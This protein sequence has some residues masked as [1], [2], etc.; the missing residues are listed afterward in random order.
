MADIGTNLDT[1][2]ETEEKAAGARA[3]RT[4]L[5]IA[6]VILAVAIGGVALVFS[7]VGQDRDRALLEWQA[8]MAIVAD[9]RTAD[10]E[11]W[12]DEQY[13]TLSGLAENASLQLYVTTL[14]EGSAGAD[15]VEAAYLRNL[16]E[17]TAQRTGFLP[18]Q[19]ETTIDANVT[20]SGLGGLAVLDAQGNAVLAVG[21]LPPQNPDILRAIAEAS[22][23]ARAMVPLTLGPDG[24]PV[25]GFAVPIYA[26]QG[27]AGSENIGTLVGLR[28]VGDD[29]WQRLRQPG[30]TSTTAEAYLVRKTG[31]TIE[32]LS[33]LADGTGPLKKSLD[34]AT[35]K[36]AAALVARRPGGFAIGRDYSGRDVL[37]TGR[38]I[39][40]APW[41]LVRTVAA[42]EALAPIARR[43][44]TLITV[45][46]LVI[47]GVLIGALALWRHGSSLRAAQSA[48][49]YRVATER[50]GNLSRF[51]R[52]VTDGQPTAISAVD[53]SGHYTFLNK[54]AAKDSGT[55]PDALI[56]KTMADVIGP[57]KAKILGAINDKVIKTGEQTSTIQT[58]QDNGA[59]RIV[60]SD[61][62]PLAPDRDHPPGVLMILEDVTELMSERARAERTMRDLVTTL[63]SLV[64]RRDPYSADQSTR[65]AQVSQAIAR[66]MGQPDDVVQTVD[67]AGNL[68]NLGKILVP[69]EILTK[70]G[71][72]SDDEISIVRDSMIHTADLLN[73]VDF[74]LP[75]AATLRQLQEHWDG[76]GFPE[77]LA[78]EDILLSARIVAVANAFV[79]MVSPRAY[80]DAMGFDKAT[81]ILMEDVG[82]RYDRK[83]VA[84]LINYL[85]NR[86]GD[87]EWA[88]FAQPPK[89]A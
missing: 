51:M 35:P 25:I 87:A 45:F 5:I 61:H 24:R 34:S 76:K 81:G 88:H 37:I 9:S 48:A 74:H 52:L 29:L 60:K 41:F 73:K 32:Y 82:T 62:I 4:M 50:L 75:V 68:M 63:V 31:D 19:A 64:D 85:T 47:V 54:G 40:G 79:S 44:T 80:R 58:F 49:R 33:P 77:G 15:E 86:G 10:V 14:V 6:A 70:T 84:A 89:D 12:L 42:E 16:L 78:G 28:P 38:A 27:G 71:R 56:G 36:L 39:S 66:E 18:R 23:G 43:Q 65:V 26:V 53:N 55:D 8:R 3:R 22:G 21:A 1:E 57:H 67:V 17:A 72:L 11:R 2:T 20:P 13:G 7:F 83:P 30:E 46:L 59:E 69:P